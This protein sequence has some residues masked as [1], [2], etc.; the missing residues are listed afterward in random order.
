MAYV[1]VFSPHVDDESFGAGGLIHKLTRTGHTVD[2]HA[3]TNAGYTEI[4]DEGRNA[5]DILGVRELVIHDFKVHTF[6]YHRQEILDA[7]I[8]VRN[9][10][11]PSIVLCPSKFDVHQDHEVVRRETERAFKGK[12]RILGYDMP[13]N[14]LAPYTFFAS[15][16]YEDA[17]AKVDAINEYKTQMTR[18]DSAEKAMQ[19][20]QH[21]GRSIDLEFAEAY[22]AI[23]WLI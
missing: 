2:V 16:S 20:L 8:K 9:T 3:F 7:M 21:Y 22:E 19:S 4:S 15:L 1:I 13:R 5:C 11:K 18:E 12:A 6:P 14:G 10:K 23:R 17:M